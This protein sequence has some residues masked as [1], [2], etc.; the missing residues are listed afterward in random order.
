V[1]TTIILFLALCYYQV[2]STP[3]QY[4][5]GYGNQFDRERYAELKRQ[6]DLNWPD[7]ERLYQYLES[8]ICK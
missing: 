3:L 2:R 7:K 5:P 6:S 1:L 8:I 4:Q